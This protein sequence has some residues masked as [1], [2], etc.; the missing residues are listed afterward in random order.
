MHVQWAMD[1]LVKQNL[2][3]YQMDHGVPMSRDVVRSTSF[4]F[5]CRLHNISVSKLLNGYKR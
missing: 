4:P 3:V 5:L 2:N 1:F